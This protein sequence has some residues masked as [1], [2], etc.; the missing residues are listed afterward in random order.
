LA[1]EAEE[2]AR[3]GNMKELYDITKKLTG[4]TTNLTD[5]LKTKRE[6]Q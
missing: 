5:Q 2:A 3:E 4:N 1:T 6:E